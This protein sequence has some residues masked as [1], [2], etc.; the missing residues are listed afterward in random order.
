MRR[1]SAGGVEPSGAGNPL[2]RGLVGLLVAGAVLMVVR[3]L[4]GGRRRAAAARA[5]NRL[6]RCADC[7][8]AVPESV[9]FVLPEGAGGGPLF[10]CGAECRRRIVT[11]A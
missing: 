3:M 9:A 1:A 10:A 11:R 2:A 7:G 6:V 5:S 4:L 8:T